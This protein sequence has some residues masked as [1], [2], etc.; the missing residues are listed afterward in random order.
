LARD[1]SPFPA[2]FCG[3][4]DKLPQYVVMPEPIS[5]NRFR[6]ILLHAVYLFSGTATV[7]IGPLLPILSRKFEL[8]DLQLG[9]FFPAQFAGSIVGTFLSSWFGRRGRYQTAVCLGGAAMAAGLLMISLG[10]F[11]LVLVGFFLNGIGIGLSL[12]SVNMLI[13]DNDP[14]KS[15]PALNILNLC[16]GLGAIFCKPFVDLTADGNSVISTVA[17][18]GS[19]LA[20]T[21]LPLL[22]IKIERPKAFG[23]ETLGKIDEPSTPIWSTSTAWLIAGFNFIHVGFESSMGG[24]LATYTDRVSDVAVVSWLSPTFLYFLLFVAGRGAAPIFFRY[25]D[26][27]K[28][29]AAGLLIM[30]AGVVIILLADGILSLNVGAAITGFGTS[31]IFPTNLSRFY[32]VFGPQ[33][34]SRIA[35]LFIMGTVGSAALTWGIGLVSD[36]S[37]ELRA[38][39]G[40]LL[41]SVVILAVLQAIISRRTF[42]KHKKKSPQ[43]L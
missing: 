11:D 20:I 34:A 2:A 22:F 27:N 28:M 31:W 40:L 21:S 8:N 14:A 33:A 42:Q 24:W 3:L 38:G 30:F 13:I 19:L 1:A 32:R 10:R 5:G 36:I 37:G 9:S 4:I 25:L 29:L 18:L 23:D 35:P 12:P 6:L 41:A 16:W 26:E 15:G 43:P 7:L 39:M 17:I